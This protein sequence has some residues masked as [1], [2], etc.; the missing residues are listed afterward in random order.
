VGADRCLARRYKPQGVN[1]LDA[2]KCAKCGTKVFP[3]FKL[4]TADRRA[5]ACSTP[6]AAQPY[7]LWGGA[8]AARR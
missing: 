4:Q 8:P 2:S 3:V 5:H 6:F 7:S 1:R